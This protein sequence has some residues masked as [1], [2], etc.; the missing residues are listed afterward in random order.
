M[1]RWAQFE[2][3]ITAAGVVAAFALGSHPTAKPWIGYTL[4]IFGLVNA[5]LVVP[6]TAVVR[7]IGAVC[8]ILLLLWPGAAPAGVLFIAWWLWPAAFLMAWHAASSSDLARAGTSA[9]AES[10]RARRTLAAVIGAVAVASIVFRLLVDTRLQ[11]TAALF[12]GIP[13]VLAI[14]TAL[15]PPSRSAVGV[16]ARSVT[17]GL[18]VSLMFLGEGFLCVLMSAPLFYLVAGA[19]ALAID[20]ARRQARS[21]PTRLLSCVGVLA[22]MPLTLEGA[23]PATTLDRESAVSV[24]AIVRATP[25]AVARA[26]VSSPRFDRTLPRYLRAG[27]PTPVATRLD[28]APVPSRPGPSRW[29]I[30]MRGGEM[31]LTGIEPRAGDLVLE[32]EEFQPGVARWRAVSDDS[33]MRHFLTWREAEVRWSDAGHGTT[34]VTWTLRYRRDLDPAWYF[35]PMERYAVRL[36]AGYLI[37]S[38]ATP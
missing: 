29:T 26:L 5:L 34:R 31:G 24:T 16:A 20:K 28:D 30:R 6:G 35:G 18:L 25:N 36:A 23:F 33:H 7:R 17:I 9:D 38:V 14:V 10:W 13:A 27:F 3:W 15:A 12:V 2:A 11:Q 4:L 21:T 1:R 19:I 37:E 32:L 22:L 8:A